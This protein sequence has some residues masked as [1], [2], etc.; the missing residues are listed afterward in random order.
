MQATQ[1]EEPKEKKDT[2]PKER[3]KGKKKPHAHIPQRL[4]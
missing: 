3:R 2:N 1:Q 4:H